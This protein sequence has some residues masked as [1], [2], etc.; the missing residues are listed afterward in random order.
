MHSQLTPPTDV[1]AWIQGFRRAFEQADVFA[2]GDLFSKTVRYRPAPSLPALEGRGA[3]E[4]HWSR[5]VVVLE[6]RLAV[7]RWL[8]EDGDTHLVHVQLHAQAPTAPYGLEAVLSVAFDEDGRCCRLEGAE[9]RPQPAD[10]ASPLAGTATLAPAAAEPV[11]PFV[12]A[13]TVAASGVPVQDVPARFG[14]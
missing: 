11:A 9:H 13:A 5:D 2:A 3:I 10:D 1:A 14:A 8:G 4:E 12:A 7:C 6:E